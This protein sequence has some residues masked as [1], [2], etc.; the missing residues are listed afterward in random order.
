MNECNT[1]KSQ[2]GTPQSGSDDEW[3]EVAEANNQEKS[4]EHF[5]KND[6]AGATK[7]KSSTVGV[8]NT[9]KSARSTSIKQSDFMRSVT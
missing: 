2:D 4:E 7:V 8:S 1:N 3:S 9:T 5:L 6:K